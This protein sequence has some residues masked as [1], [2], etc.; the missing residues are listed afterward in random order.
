MVD[1]RGFC[2][3]GKVVLRIIGNCTYEVAVAVTVEA[4]PALA[5]NFR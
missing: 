2:K 5:S 3:D 4:P 1:K